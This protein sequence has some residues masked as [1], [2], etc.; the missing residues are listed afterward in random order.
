MFS[1]ASNHYLHCNQIRHHPCHHHH[2]KSQGKRLGNWAEA[3]GG[4]G[5]WLVMADLFVIFIRMLIYSNGSFFC[6]DTK[7]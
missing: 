6:Y 1:T 3:G 5:G 2:Q 7:I 4:G